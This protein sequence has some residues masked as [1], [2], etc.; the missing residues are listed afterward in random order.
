MKIFASD[1]DGTLRTKELVSEENKQAI[2]TWRNAGN[3]FVLVS[4]R[5]LESMKREIE[6]NRFE[7]DYI[8]G[9]NGGAI[10]DANF[11]E[12][13][14]YYFPFQE[15]TKIISYIKQERTI[16]YVLNDG[17]H[18]SKTILDPSREDK[19]YANTKMT[20]TEKELLEKKKIAQIVV[21]LDREEDTRRI[22]DHINSLFGHV[23]CA[24]RNVNCV[25][26]APY[27]VSKSTGLAY[28]VHQTGVR[29]EAVYTIGDSFNDIPMLETFIG[30]AM[31]QAP[32][33][34]KSYASHIVKQPSDAIMQILCATK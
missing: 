2:H 13:K 1:Y 17:F 5:S 3:L 9:N 21:S 15:A 33:Q 25:D 26:V 24:Y 6:V 10:Y 8:I 29:H 11:H 34:V 30:F 28:I 18:R 16:S 23:A 31:N 20:Y 19:K 4:G 12:L 7:V 14:S 27:G 32:A 22:S